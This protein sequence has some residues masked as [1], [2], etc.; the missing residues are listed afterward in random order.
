MILLSYDVDGKQS[1]VK[2]RLCSKA[3]GYL[4]E[5][6][7]AVGGVS[8]LPDT[9]VIY[10]G[11]R[12]TDE[13]FKDVQNAAAAEGVKVTRFAAVEFPLQSSRFLKN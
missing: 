11:S 1:E 4:K 7:L 8:K 2:N 6:P 5:M 12:T 10:Q 13:A 3:I 9:T